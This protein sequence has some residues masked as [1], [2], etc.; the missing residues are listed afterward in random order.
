MVFLLFVAYTQIARP[1]HPL[2]KQIVLTLLWFV[3]AC[4]A[5]YFTL[6]HAYD[7]R[8]EIGFWRFIGYGL[9]MIVIFLGVC[10]ALNHI[11]GKHTT[12]HRSH[13]H[14]SHA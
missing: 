14:R 12:P 2:V 8:D 5:L 7:A 13:D 10:I 3:S 11:D 6:T 1:R 4:M 9:A